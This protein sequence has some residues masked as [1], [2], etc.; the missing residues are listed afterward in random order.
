[1]GE[2]YPREGHDKRKMS[3]NSYSGP[4]RLL[5]MPKNHERKN[6]SLEINIT[7]INI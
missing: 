6:I 5:E 7:F 2:A 4:P 3:T 1:M